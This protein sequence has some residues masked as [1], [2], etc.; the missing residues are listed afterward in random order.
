M[1]AHVNLAA[2]FIFT[3]YEADTEAKLIEQF[4]E[5][6]LPYDEIHE[7]QFSQSWPEMVQMLTHMG[8]LS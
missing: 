1:Q 7:I 4:E 5:L 2:G 8:R 6:G 3:I